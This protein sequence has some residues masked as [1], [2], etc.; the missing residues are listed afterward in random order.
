MLFF[1]ADPGH[2][3]KSRHRATAADGEVQ[4]AVF[5]TDDDIGERQRRSIQELFE[6]ALIR[7]AVRSQMARIEFA[8]APIATE[9]SFLILG[10]ELGAIAEDH[11]G[12]A[13][14]TDV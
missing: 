3:I 4:C 13:A 5:R 8:V 12:G 14:G 11:A 10:G 1:L 6:F 2:T 7:C 9:K